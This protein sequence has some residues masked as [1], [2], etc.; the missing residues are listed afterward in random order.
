MSTIETRR[1]L[2]QQVSATL[3]FATAVAVAAILAL[4]WIGAEHESQKAV[5]TATAAISG[6]SA[7]ATQTAQPAV[8]VAGRRETAST[9][10]R[11]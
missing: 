8:A 2:P 1:A 7:Q 5:Q 6:G 10:K 11:I 4:A 9:A 3:R